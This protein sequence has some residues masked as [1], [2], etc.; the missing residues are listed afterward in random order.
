VL[1]EK[2]EILTNQDCRGVLH[3]RAVRGCELH[4]HCDFFE[5]H[6][7]LEAAWMAEKGPIRDLYRGILQVAVA[8]YHIQRGNYLGAKK[9][10]QRSHRW[11]APFPDICRGIQVEQFRVDASQAEERLLQSGAEGL[12]Q[13]PPGLF[14]KVAGVN[15][16]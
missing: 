3:P 8:C 6:E 5:A 7:E 14:P 11:L 13:F 9:M 15:Q 12:S 1:E 4:N 10:F 16:Y 2:P